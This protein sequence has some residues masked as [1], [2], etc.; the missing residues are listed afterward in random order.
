[1]EVYMAMA[2]RSN[3]QKNTHAPRIH[4][5]SATLHDKDMKDSTEYEGAHDAVGEDARK[6][7]DKARRHNERLI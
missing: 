3:K 7:R 2:S 1:M 5:N 4:K 6:S